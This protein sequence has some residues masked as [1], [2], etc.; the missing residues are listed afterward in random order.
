MTYKEYIYEKANNVRTR[1]QLNELLDE[2]VN[3]DVLDYAEIVHA[4]S[5]C[6]IATANYINRSEVGGITGFQA[7]LI[8]WEIIAKFMHESKVAMRLIDYED[9]LYP[10]Y[11]Y[12][13]AK[14]ISKST[15]DLL[16][17]EAS[18]RLLENPN[19]HPEVI[20]HWKSIVDGKV[21]FGYEVKDN[22]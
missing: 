14:T 13:F 18:K 1:E 12:E 21:P 10:Q 19:A 6:M 2:V 16:Q 3:S 4:I 17:D 7:S 9:M 15:W 11:D 5:G 8:A 20:K 22:E